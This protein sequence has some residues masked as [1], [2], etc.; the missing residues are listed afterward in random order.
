MITE[1]FESR[2]GGRYSIGAGLELQVISVYLYSTK[3]CLFHSTRHV[4][5]ALMATPLKL[6]SESLQ[7]SIYYEE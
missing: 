2:N 6:K 3:M 7:D 1:F 4:M 5:V